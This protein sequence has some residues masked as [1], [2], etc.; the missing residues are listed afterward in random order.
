MN[1]GGSLLEFRAPL[2]RSDSLASKA[3]DR[4]RNRI[5]EQL[6]ALVKTNAAGPFSLKQPKIR[7]QSLSYMAACGRLRELLRS[8]SEKRL[9]RLREEGRRTPDLSN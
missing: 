1:I 5:H 6:G 3:Y 4:R 9:E 7:R 8:H 2:L